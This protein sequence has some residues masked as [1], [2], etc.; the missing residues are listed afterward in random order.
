MMR[1]YLL[2]VMKKLL[3]FSR[4]EEESYFFKGR[5]TLRENINPFGS[6]FFEGRKKLSVELVLQSMTICYEWFFF[7]IQLMR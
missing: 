5:K 3:S 7:M 6:L 2:L 1:F 4:I